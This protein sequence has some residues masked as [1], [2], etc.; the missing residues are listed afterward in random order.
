MRRA[1]IAA[2]S[3][4]LVWLAMPASPTLAA[5]PTKVVVIVGPSG[6]STAHYKEDANQVVAEAR[7][8]TSDVVKVYTPNATW[9]AVKAAAQGA[10]ILVYLGHGN[11]WPS[12]YPP[13]Q[14][15]T[16]DGLGLDP[17]TGANSTK[18]VYYGEDWI[19]NH[20]RLAPNAVVLLYHLCYASGNTE[21]GLAVGTFADARLRVD[22]YG[23]GF[24]GAG[25]RA[26]FA[27]GHPS[28]PVVSYVR[29]LFTTNRTME[30]VF[31]VVPTFKNH[32]LGPYASQRTPGLQ[33]L[34]DPDSS[35]PSGFYRSLV[36]DL[37][38]RAQ[39]TVAPGIERTDAHP[40]DFVVP[41]A[42]QVAVD[43]GAGVYATPE[44]AADPAATAPVTLPNDTRLRVTSEEAPAADGTRILGVSAL[45]G[46]TRGFA[47]AS[48]LVPRDS[49][50]VAVW[51][52]DQSSEWL[53]P[54]GDNVN[55]GLVV[56]VRVTETAAT[57]FAVKNAAGT[58]V[59]ALSLTTDFARVAW[60]LHTPAGALV[61]DGGYTW[62][63][64]AAD[65]WGNGTLARS[66]TFIVDGTAPVTT[67]VTE[68]TAGSNGW[69]VT[70]PSV[71]LTARDALSGVKSI[72]WRVNGG[73]A[74]YGSR[75]TVTAD[76]T[77]AFEYRATDNAGIREAWKTVTLKIDTTAPSIGIPQAGNAGLAAGTWRGPVTLA[78]IVRDATSGLAAASIAVD[79]I[80]ATRLGA[81]PITVDGEGPH[82]ITVIGRDNAGNRG[83][84]TVEFVIDT[85]APSIEVPVPGDTV[86]TVTPNGDATGE[87]VALP[88]S[89]SEPGSV[90]AVVTDGAAAVVRTINTPAVAG[91]NELAWDGRNDAG[92]P[93]ADGRYTVTITPLDAA[94]NP[95]GPA[96][97]E[98]DAYGALKALTRT[99]ASFFPQDGDALATRTRAAFTLLAPATVTIRVLD[100]DG[101][102]VRA[103]MTDKALPAGAASWAWNGKDD[104]GAYV[105]RG[106]YR[107]VVT[108]TNGTQATSQG[109]TVATEAFR[110]STSATTA[111]RG[112]AFTVTAVSVEPLSTT[113][114]VVVRQ[115]GM[116]PWT[117]TMTK[118]TAT[119]WTAIVKPRR[120][121]TAGT[122][123]LTVKATDS[124]GGAN[125]SVIRLALQ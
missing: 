71:T 14:T 53:S 11:G 48:A 35:A 7:R 63:F 119:T 77:Q 61:P 116:D 115:P 101:T 81:D 120:G 123:R 94:G 4:M 100:K 45:G 107:I 114:K 49:T 70:S 66:G 56:A 9:T 75:A 34:M 37:S 68:A 69:F 39:D 78:P 72:A 74:T 3:L 12:I 73:K 102:L 89:V 95:G 43:A 99:P 104:A 30:Q 121:G 52:L 51:T 28:H 6:G 50:P 83:T 25:A 58:T 60:D 98:V 111:T 41:G 19:R 91:A 42:A 85:T 67:A 93:V 23:A 76:G 65:A 20:I 17:G 8:Y 55:D 44:A 124:R 46:S 82:T 21:P 112:K 59:K 64:R 31:R 15:L 54:N 97:V 105:P 80:P 122:L 26:V 16:K 33:F 113:P 92:K 32:V 24:I 87:R 5:S 88:F 118:R 47:R 57:S 96:T 90:V 84:A 125:S 22:N 106:I 18:T 10:N 29:Q 79:G 13:F 109:V 110:L 1:L 86:P 62:S 36:G 27:E 2:L 108:A 38:L 117:I 40:A 103:G